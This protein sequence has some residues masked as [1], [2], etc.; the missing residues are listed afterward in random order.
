MLRLMWNEIKLNASLLL[1]IFMLMNLGLI[2]Y[3]ARMP[4][5]VRFSALRIG[6]GYAMTMPLIA[7]LREA[8]Y[9]GYIVNRSLPLSTLRLVL[10]RYC[11]LILLGLVTIAYGFLYQEILESLV[12]RLSRTYLSWHMIESGYGI[13]HSLIARGLGY[14]ALLAIAVPLVVRYGSFWRL[15]I[16]YLAVQAIWGRFVD[17]L[18]ELSLHSSIFLGMS[19]WVFFASLSCI[20]ILAISVQ[21]SVWLCKLRDF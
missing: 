7:L 16:A 15:V 2:M 8:Y 18:L 19:R 14:S 4:G 6:V 20:I 21:V 5:P 12:P 3:A 10:A 9:K 17:L 11:S 1:L 13:E